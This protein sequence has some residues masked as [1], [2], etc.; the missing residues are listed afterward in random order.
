VNRSSKPSSTG[1]A[2]VAIIAKDTKVSKATEIYDRLIQYNDETR[3]VLEDKIE[4][5]PLLLSS[6]LPTVSLGKL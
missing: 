4:V 6:K 5:L 1:A 3:V 2:I